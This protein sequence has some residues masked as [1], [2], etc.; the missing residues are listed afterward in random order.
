MDDIRAPPLEHE[1]QL[2]AQRGR[3]R[4]R[5]AIE[6]DFQRKR[7]AK[8]KAPTKDVEYMDDVA[9]KDAETTILRH[10]EYNRVDDIASHI[11]AAID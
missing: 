5:K 11:D 9:L 1:E 4:T 2:D 3:Q 8:G 7:K 6:G 10:F